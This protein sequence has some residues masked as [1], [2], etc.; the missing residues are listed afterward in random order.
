[1]PSRSGADEARARLERRLERL[2]AQHEWGDIGDAAYLAKMQ[3]TRTDLALLP[4]PEKIITFDGVAAI[5]KSM[6]SAID[7]A[8][9][10]KLKELVGLLVDKIV[11]AADGTYEIEFVAAARPFFAEQPDLLMAPP[12]G[13]EPPTPALGRLRSVH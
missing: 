6:A 13:L 12:D 11:A 8:S 3:E 4:E 10:E 2:K 9:P 7:A 5:A 1:M